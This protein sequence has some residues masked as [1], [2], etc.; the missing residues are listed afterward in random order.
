MI[1]FNVNA[2]NE[3]ISLEDIP[4]PSHVAVGAGS[5]TVVGVLDASVTAN[6]LEERIMLRE[7][8]TTFFGCGSVCVCVALFFYTMF[9]IIENDSGAF[10]AFLLSISCVFGLGGLVALC[11]AYQAL[12]NIYSF[13][14]PNGTIINNEPINEPIST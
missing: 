11:T 1:C 12:L 13:Y 5:A 4:V 7:Y 8:C 2:P 6:Q 14:F 10:F 3:T 9:F